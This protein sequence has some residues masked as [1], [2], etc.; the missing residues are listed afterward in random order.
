MSVELGILELVMIFVGPVVVLL[1]VTLR[2][3][4]KR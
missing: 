2:G 4:M 1:V 3:K